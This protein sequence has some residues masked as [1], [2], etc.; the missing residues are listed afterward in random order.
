MKANQKF[1]PKYWIVHDPMSD[2]VFI[3]TASKSWDDAHDKGEM[4]FGNKMH[5]DNGYKV[6]LVSIESLED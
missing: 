6:I 2:D 3:E 4:F 1:S 5:E